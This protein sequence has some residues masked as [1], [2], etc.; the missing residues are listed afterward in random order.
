MKNSV[1]TSLAVVSFAAFAFLHPA[2]AQTVAPASAAMTAEQAREENAYAVGLQAYLW[3]FP[4]RYY[5][6][7]IPKSVEIGGVYINDFRKF[8]EL[9]TAKDDGSPGLRCPAGRAYSPDKS[10]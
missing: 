7:A 9:K 4:L 1:I 6:R 10:T 8:T 5:S 3:G 2:G